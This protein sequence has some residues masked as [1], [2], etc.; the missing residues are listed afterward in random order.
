MNTASPNR[1][2]VVRAAGLR[3]GWLKCHEP[4]AFTGALLNSLP[5]GFYA[6]AQLVED[7]RRHGVEVRP[8][9]VDA[10]DWDCTLESSATSPHGKQGQSRLPVQI[11]RSKRSDWKSV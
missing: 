8:A 4:A 11:I 9:D 2:G 5:M 7:V 3:V 10:S 6:P 1:T